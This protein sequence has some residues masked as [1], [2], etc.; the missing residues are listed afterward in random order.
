M[1]M[2][3]LCSQ[4]MTD[5]QQGHRPRSWH[6]DGPEVLSVND[7]GGGGVVLINIA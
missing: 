3:D 1:G 4:A 7:G 2:H 5:Q 6:H